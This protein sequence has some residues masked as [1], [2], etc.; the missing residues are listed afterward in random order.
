MRRLFTFFCSFPLFFFL[1]LKREMKCRVSPLYA[2]LSLMKSYVE[3]MLNAHLHESPAAFACREATAAGQ[4]TPDFILPPGKAARRAAEACNVDPWL[5]A[6]CDDPQ[7][8][9]PATVA[10]SI[11]CTDLNMGTKYPSFLDLQ[12]SLL[13]I[14]DIHLAVTSVATVGVA[15]RATSNC[16][17]FARGTVISWPENNDASFGVVRLICQV[18]F[19]PGPAGG[20]TCITC[21]R[22]TGCCGHI[23][24][25]A[26]QAT[27]TCVQI[28][29]LPA[30]NAVRWFETTD[31]AI[32]DVPGA[33]VHTVSR[34]SVEAAEK[35]SLPLGVIPRWILAVSITN[36]FVRIPRFKDADKK[37]TDEDY[38]VETYH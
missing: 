37:A 38:L 30:V 4:P 34:K 10:G 35:K 20:R 25:A 3:I 6:R 24:H 27:V 21:A 7:L 5:F 23:N 1:L 17:T 19:I 14:T 36:T 12:R 8:V 31:V 11:K 15:G 13:V 29:D 26:A 9:S 28:V 18:T 16:R 32:K 22:G 2:A 33:V